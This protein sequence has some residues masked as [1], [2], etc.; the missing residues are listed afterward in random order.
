[1]EL[2]AAVQKFSEKNGQLG[3][4]LAKKIGKLIELHQQTLRQAENRLSKL[5]QVCVLGQESNSSKAEIQWSLFLLKINQKI[6]WTMMRVVKGSSFYT[7]PVSLNFTCKLAFILYQTV[8]SVHW[9]TWSYNGLWNEYFVNWRSSLWNEYSSS[10]MFYKISM[11]SNI[12][13]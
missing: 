6:I 12:L 1:M 8:L 9:Q 2:D 11:N 4:P 3:K 7:T 5:G 10:N 13:K